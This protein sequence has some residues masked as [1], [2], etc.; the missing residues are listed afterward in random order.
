MDLTMLPANIQMTARD[1]Y[2]RNN[3]I[4]MDTLYSQ[5][6]NQANAKYDTTVKMGYKYQSGLLFAF[7]WVY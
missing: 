3:N 7:L 2:V 4:Q 1:E 6:W 5:L